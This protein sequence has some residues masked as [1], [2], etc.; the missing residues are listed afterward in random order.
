[1]RRDTAL[2]EEDVQVGPATGGAG[3]PIAGMTIG[4]RT[5]DRPGLHIPGSPSDDR[6]R[7]DG[8]DEPAAG[9]AIGR[10]LLEDLVAKFQASS[11]T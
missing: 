4:R 9:L 1:M 11:R 6:R 8:D 2:L 3:G 7:R 10:L 5:V